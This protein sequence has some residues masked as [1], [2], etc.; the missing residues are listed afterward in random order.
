MDQRRSERK[1]S[2]NFLDIEH[3]AHGGEVLNQGMGRTLDVSLVGLK[4]ETHLP[5]KPGEDLQV[6]IGLDDDVVN[7]QGRIVHVSEEGNDLYHA[8]V[9]FVDLDADQERVLKRYL[10]AFNAVRST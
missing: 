1:D 3:V 8:G 10:E 4:L 6:A 2:L 7:L 5:L 9:E